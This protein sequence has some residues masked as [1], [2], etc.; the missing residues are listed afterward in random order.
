ME[1]NLNDAI[2]VDDGDHI[3]ADFTGLGAYPIPTSMG[4]IDRDDQV[5][6]VDMEIMAIPHRLVPRT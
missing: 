5:L 3:G 1:I 2:G 6:L 4:Y